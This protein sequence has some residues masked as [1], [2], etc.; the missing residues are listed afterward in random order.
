MVVCERFPG[1]AIRYIPLRLYFK[2]AIDAM[3]RS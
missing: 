1:Y 3:G 2:R